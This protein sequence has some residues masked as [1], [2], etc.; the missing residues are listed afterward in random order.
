MFA[1][2]ET[3]SLPT[4]LG[5][6]IANKGSYFLMKFDKVLKRCG[7]NMTSIPQIHLIKLIHLSFCLLESFC[8]MLYEISKLFD[9]QLFV[10]TSTIM[11]K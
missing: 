10:D 2:K 8:N 1:K 11:G 6:S 5:I 3:A 4:L 7:G 9:I